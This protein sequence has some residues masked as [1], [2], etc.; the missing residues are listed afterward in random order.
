MELAYASGSG[1]ELVEQAPRV[2]VTAASRPQDKE[3][4]AFSKR[5][6]V[7]HFIPHLTI[8]S[9]LCGGCSSAHQMLTLPIIADDVGGVNIEDAEIL[10]F[11]ARANFFGGRGSGLCA[12]AGDDG[13]YESLGCVF[14]ERSRHA[15]QVVDGD[16][17]EAVD[18]RPGSERG[19]HQLVLALK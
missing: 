12:E 7:L 16:H 6:N 14:H 13:A 11:L 1:R 9:T 15:D 17:G 10:E 3:E 4:R 2:R 5:R 18:R 19:D 8:C